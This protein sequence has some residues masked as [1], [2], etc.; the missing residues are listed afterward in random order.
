MWLYGLLI[1]M[2]DFLRM[3]ARQRMEKSS[4]KPNKNEMEEWI[5]DMMIS[6]ME[7]D[8]FKAIKA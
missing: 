4:N 3:F 1:N 5:I 8:V 6:A 7:W 2:H